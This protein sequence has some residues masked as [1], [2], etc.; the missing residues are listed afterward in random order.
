MNNPPEELVDIIDAKGRFI[1]T[2]PKAR[3]H[4]KGLLHRVVIGLLKNSR[5]EYCFVRQSASRQD[6]GQFV[7]P[8]GGHVASGETLEDA[9]IRES[10]EEVGIGPVKYHFV[11]KTIFNREVI[12]RKE[13]HLFFIYI[14]ETDQN[15]VLNH[16]SVEY[17]WFNA[18]DIKQALASKDPAFGGA[19]HHVFQNLSL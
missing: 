9:L 17:K 5:G 15:P 13:N 18:R 4:Q 14:I 8:I 11:T 1:S 12:G 16:E 10:Q 3:A 7:S 6:A 19:W 2:V